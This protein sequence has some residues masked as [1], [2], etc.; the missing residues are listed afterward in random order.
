MN[1]RI[2]VNI[3]VIF[4]ISAVMF[5][6]LTRKYTNIEVIMQT[7]NIIPSVCSA[8]KS[9]LKRKNKHK[10]FFDGFFADLMKNSTI[11][12]VKR[13]IREYNLTSCAK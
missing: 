1:G 6:L 2:Y 12:D 10:F 13:K 8:H 7:E 11:K 3:D 4:F 9:A 5:P